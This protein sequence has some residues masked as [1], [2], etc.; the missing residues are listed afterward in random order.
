MSVG[1]MTHHK[2]FLDVRRSCGG[3]RISWCQ[4]KC[5]SK[6]AVTVCWLL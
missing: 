1:V 5:L 6:S 4:C 2:G 3:L